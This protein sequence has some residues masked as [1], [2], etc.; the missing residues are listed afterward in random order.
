M[1]GTTFV[2]SDQKPAGT[3]HDIKNKV[4]IPLPSRNDSCCFYLPLKYIS[5]KGI[6]LPHY[7]QLLGSAYFLCCLDRL[8]LEYSLPFACSSQSQRTIFGAPFFLVVK[9][10]GSISSPNSSVCPHGPVMD[11]ICDLFLADIPYLPLMSF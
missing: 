3:S 7:C 2:S 6:S 1:D 11:P 5:N 9:N 8:L 4:Q 10:G